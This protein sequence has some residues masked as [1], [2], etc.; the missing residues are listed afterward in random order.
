MEWY[1][2]LKNVG[3]PTKMVMFDGEGH[4]L[5]RGGTPVNLVER[6]NQMLRWFDQWDGVE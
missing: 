4:G 2:A 6:L 5:S 3:V 1:Y